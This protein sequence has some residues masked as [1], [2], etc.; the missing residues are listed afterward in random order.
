MEALRRILL[1]AGA[2]A[3]ALPVAA[4]FNPS[5]SDGALACGEGG[6][7]PPGF[8][9]R[10]A[11]Q[12]CYRDPPAT[13][14]DGAPADRDGAPDEPDATADELD[15]SVLADGGGEDAGSDEAAT[16]CATYE[17]ICG[18]SGSGNRYDDLEA[19]LE[20]FDAYDAERQACV[21]SELEQAEGATGGAR[22]THCSGA[23]GNAPCT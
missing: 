10:A 5:E 12:R 7:C 1:C 16:F 23:A 11:D 18:F 21:E 4:C 22:N 19:C 20:A 8:V 14:L 15:G 17:Q 9:C 2:L 13:D 3:L 6:A